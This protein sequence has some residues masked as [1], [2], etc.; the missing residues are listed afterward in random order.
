[1]ASNGG[2]PSRLQST[3][4]VA[5]VAGLGSFGTL[6]SAMRTGSPAEGRGS[7][8]NGGGNRG[9]VRNSRLI[10]VNEVHR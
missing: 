6:S 9:V 1:M 7:L 4:L 5:A 3:R 10:P 8:G 2:A